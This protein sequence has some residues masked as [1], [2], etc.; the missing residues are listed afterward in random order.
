MREA[1]SKDGGNPDTTKFVEL[2]FADAVTALKQ[3][4]VDAISTA[5][6]YA[7]QLRQQGFR[8]IGD[9][10]AIAFGNPEADNTDYYMS[11]QFVDQHP[12]IVK[13]W[14]TALQKASDYA[15]AHPDETRAKIVEQTKIDPALAAA[16]PLPKY[17]AQ[18]DQPTIQ[19]E[20]SFLVK[21]GVIQKAPD[22]KSLVAQ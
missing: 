16:A 8:D 7:T 21:Y 15:N 17:T 9:S 4:K 14:Q 13:R 1:I 22:V 5:Q 19:K 20:A 11:K 12:G 10:A 3:G 2:H 18:V 6:P